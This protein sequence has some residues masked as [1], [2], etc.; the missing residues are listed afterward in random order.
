M[1]AFVPGLAGGWAGVVV[2]PDCQAYAKANDQKKCLELVRKH[3][4]RTKTKQQPPQGQPPSNGG[5]GA[6]SSSGNVSDRSGGGGAGGNGTAGD[7]NGA[8]CALM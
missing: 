6:G 5:A 1:H 7:A 8:G 2:A 4:A 3:L